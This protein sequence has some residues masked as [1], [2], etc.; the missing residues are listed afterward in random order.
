MFI[1]SIPSIS[2]I[3]G[4]YSLPHTTSIDILK[5]YIGQRVKIPSGYKEVSYNSLKF[6]GFGGYENEIYKIEDVSIN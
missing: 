1:Y 3:F 2:Q 4:E 6:E 5:K